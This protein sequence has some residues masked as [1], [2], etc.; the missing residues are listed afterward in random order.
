M[1]AGSSTSQAHPAPPP[2]DPR[3]GSEDRPRKA[4]AIWQTLLHFRGPEIGDGVWLDVGCG[5]GGIA[6]ALAPRV[7]RIIGLDPEPWERWPMWM[8]AHPNLTFLE[9]SYDSIPA[10]VPAESV[11]VVVCNQVY[12]HVPDP[13]GLIAFIHR[14]LKPGGVCY[15]AGP[16]LLFPIEPHVFWPFVHWLPRRLAVS[17]MQRMGSSAVLDADST[18]YWRLLSWTRPFDVTNA[19]PQ[20]LR[21]PTNYGRRGP[22]WRL[23]SRIP[24]A[25]LAS[26]T[27][28]SPGFVF[29]LKKRAR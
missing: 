23:L 28:L 17:L 20:I 19:V 1:R 26:L 29:V 8:E 22:V 24:T 7:H 27:P 4:E 9:G 6:A 5:S 18:H 25:L 14:T 21:D 13:V 16:N 2:S 3:W 12:E 15:F 10:R 11:D